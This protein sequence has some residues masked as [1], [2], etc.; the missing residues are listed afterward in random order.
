MFRDG[1]GEGGVFQYFNVGCTF[2]YLQRARASQPHRLATVENVQRNFNACG[3]RMRP[4]HCQRALVDLIV[5]SHREDTQWLD[6]LPASVCIWHYS[7]G[8]PS[9][10]EAVPVPNTGREALSYLQHLQRLL[11]GGL[12][13]APVTVFAQGM[14]H[15]AW[16]AHG[17]G[18]CVQEF[19][20]TLQSLSATDIDKRGGVVAIG[21]YQLNSFSSG[22][23]SS[24]SAA[25]ERNSTDDPTD[26]CYLRTFA[27]MSGLESTGA[28]HLFGALESRGSYQP[29]AQFAVSRRALVELSPALRR[30]FTR[31]DRQMRS[32]DLHD[33]GARGY[34]GNT[35]C[36]P[37]SKRP[38]RL[39]VNGTC[40]ELTCLPWL[41]ERLWLP[42]FQLDHLVNASA[43]TSGRLGRANAA[44]M[45]GADG[46]GGGGDGEREGRA[47]G[48]G[49][50]DGGDGFTRFWRNGS[51]LAAVLM[52]E[53]RHTLRQRAQLPPLL[54][55]VDRSLGTLTQAAEAAA[56]VIQDST[57][58]PPIKWE[59]MRLFSPTAFG[60]P[61]ASAMYQ[62]N[63]PLSAIHRAV[64][65]PTPERL[66]SLNEWLAPRAGDEGRLHAGRRSTVQRG[67]ES[68]FPTL[69]PLA[70][71]PT[72]NG[73]RGATHRRPMAAGAG[74]HGKGGPAT[75][76]PGMVLLQQLRSLV[77]ASRT[78]ARYVREFDATAK[79]ALARLLSPTAFEA[80]APRTSAPLEW[81]HLICAVVDA[82][83]HPPANVG[84]RSALLPRRE[85]GS[86]AAGISA[87]MQELQASWDCGAPDVLTASP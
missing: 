50:A 66:H 3:Y 1:G 51:A 71:C 52:S 13:P 8:Q 6:R 76:P 21:S 41:L 62:L 19:G 10:A 58:A 4:S 9:R 63:K 67:E 57:V 75:Q 64:A 74:V 27:R 2:S 80:A 43:V 25:R 81:A 11:R 33:S 17:D 84:N 53:T 5:A 48:N 79:R 42:L 77:A 60:P 69:S 16:D 22:L 20:D 44:A 18:A 54:G 38:P 32:P 55:W 7:T 73:T 78:A 24:S 23:P 14:P 65:S 28:A 46:D 56:A 40:L 61:V 30:W 45:D 35:C 86:C 59:V 29:G 47:A 31:A 26:G 37:C 72:V 70:A 36:L 68:A 87:G 49:G 85:A 34:D 15:C 39:R 82:Q 83:P 12:T